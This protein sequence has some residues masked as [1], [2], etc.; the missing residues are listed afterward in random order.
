[1]TCMA[2]LE[3]GNLDCRICKGSGR[4]CDE[5]GEPCEPG[6][7]HCDFCKREDSIEEKGN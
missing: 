4:L 1:M 5:C 7:S 2:C 3:T 6:E